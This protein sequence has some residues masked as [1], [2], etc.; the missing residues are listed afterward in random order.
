VTGR[1]LVRALSALSLHKL[2]QITGALVFAILI[3]R[4]LGPELFGQLSFVLALSLLLHMVG[5]LGG[6]DIMGRFVPGWAQEGAAG[7]GRIGGLVWQ[8]TWVRFGLGVLITLAL[9]G[10]GHRLAPWLGPDRGALVGL[11][12]ALRLLSWAPY[13]LSFG[14]NRMGRWAVELSWRQWAMIPCLLI[15]RRWGLDGLLVGLLVAEAVFVAPGVFWLRPYGRPLRP[16]GSALWPYL[17]FGLGFFL[18]NVLVVLLYRSGPV[19]LEVLTRDTVAVGYFGLALSLYMLLITIIGQYLTA[20]V[21]TLALLVTRGQMAEARRRLEQ[22]IHHGTLVMGGLLIGLGLLIGPLAPLL[23]GADFGPVGRL[24]LWLSL[25]LPLQPLVSAG[26]GAAAAFGQPRVALLA[27]TIGLAGGLAAGLFLIPIHGAVGAGLS[28]VLGVTATA[29]T[30]LL[31]G[32]DWLRPPWR[33]LAVAALPLVLV[34]RNPG[35]SLPMALLV[36]GPALTIYL[37]LV[38]CSRGLSLTDLRRLYVRLRP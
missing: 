32:R 4:S 7:R 37:L 15:G 30:L 33:S 18:A 38:V 26:R 19:L 9:V 10:G 6:L 20:F 22:V 11:G 28:L 2:G 13:H 23:F 29:A 16:D 36:T 21:P 25:A 35:L 17:R 34:F 3:P 5:D 12:V 1:P 8:L 27:M 31:A 14:L 24:F